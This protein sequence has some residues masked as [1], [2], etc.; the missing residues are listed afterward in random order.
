MV[1][2]SQARGEAEEQERRMESVLRRRRQWGRASRFHF[3]PTLFAPCTASASDVHRFAQSMAGPSSR[4][5]LD[6]TWP[7]FQVRLQLAN[8]VG[9][10]VES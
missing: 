7:P 8:V 5:G 2:V 4:R 6:A 10:G 3:S 9:F 1:V